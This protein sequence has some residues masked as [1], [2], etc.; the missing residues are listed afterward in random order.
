MS[1]F[2]WGKLRIDRNTKLKDTD[3]TQMQDAPLTDEQKQRWAVYRQ[4]LRD[5]PVNTTNPLEPNWPT[6]PQ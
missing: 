2:D 4:D 6:P 3:W 5:L 1:D